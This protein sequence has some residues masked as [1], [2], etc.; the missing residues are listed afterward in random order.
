M[1]AS[2]PEDRQ[3]KD[4][5]TNSQPDLPRFDAAD[6]DDFLAQLIAGDRRSRSWREKLQ[7]ISELIEKT[8][9][10]L[11]SEQLVDFAL[12]LRFLG[13]G[14]IRCTE[15]GRH[16]RPAHHARLSARIQ[17]QL[18]KFNALSDQLVLRKVYP[19]LPSS[20]SD[21]Q[22]PEP[23]TR[24]RDIAH[25]NDIESELKREIKTRLQNK[26]H[27]CAGPEDLAT[28]SEILERIS[29]P[30]T[31]YP[32]A[33][34]AEFRIFHQEL[35]EFFN[36]NSLEDRLKALRPEAKP[37]LVELIDNFLN[38]K[39]NVGLSEQ[40][41]LLE[42][43][44]QL[45][46]AFAESVSGRSPEETQDIVLTDISL[47]DFAFA[48]LSQMINA[49]DHLAPDKAMGARIKML[50]LALRNIALIPTDVQETRALLAELTAW[51]IPRAKAPREE[52][53]RLRASLLRCRRLAED[54]SVRIVSLFASKAEK[55]GRAVGVSEHA[56]RVFAEAD[57]R[58]HLIFQV[59][60]LTDALLR[61]IREVLALSHWDVIVPGKALGHAAVLSS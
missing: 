11:T 45:R 46:E 9:P 24:I 28:S 31:N 18:A 37:S 8:Q 48:L 52:T 49:C 2:T 22:R 56:Y 25:R 40:R 57:I 55:V 21:F 60:K 6:H 4:L 41:A 16:F 44:T 3:V 1:W 7:F 13:T 19:W 17:E 61:S 20:S 10:T 33:F 30:G 39:G 27:R 26:L 59:S 53:L 42:T 54:F 43:L 14:A 50:L 35:K 51:G 38:Q 58:S 12:Y 34:V 29:A 5:S 23:L 36:A 32:S 47:E 15:D